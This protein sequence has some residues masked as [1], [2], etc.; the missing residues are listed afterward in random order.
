LIGKFV[1]SLYLF[2]QE[3]E[4]CPNNSQ[5]HEIR[6]WGWVSKVAPPGTQVYSHSYNTMSCVHVFC[7]SNKCKINESQFFYQI[8]NVQRLILLLNFIIG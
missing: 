4:W 6:K 8:L 5:V 2:S 1:F 7:F 3:E